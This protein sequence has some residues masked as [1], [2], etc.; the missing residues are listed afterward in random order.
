MSSEVLS[1]SAFPV[2]DFIYRVTSYIPYGILI[3]LMLCHCNTI[4]HNNDAHVQAATKRN[5]MKTVN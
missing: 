4:M 3:K 1:Y 5:N 2:V